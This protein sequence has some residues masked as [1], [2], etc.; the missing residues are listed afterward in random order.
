[1]NLSCALVCVYIVYTAPQVSGGRRIQASPLT[2]A[3]TRRRRCQTLLLTRSRNN[4]RAGNKG[5]AAVKSTVARSI[6]KPCERSAAAAKGRQNTLT[7]GLSAAPRKTE[8]TRPRQEPYLQP[9][10]I[11]ELMPIYRYPSVDSSSP[12]VLIA[13]IVYASEQGFVFF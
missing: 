1:M 6:L 12:V 3:F 9:E 7:V 2:L 10:R 11:T 13:C 4:C 8:S 5:L